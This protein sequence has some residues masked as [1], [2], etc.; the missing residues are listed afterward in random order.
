MQPK[1]M[2][3]ELKSGYADDGPA[4]IGMAF[5][6]KTGRTIYF[7]GLVLKKGQ[8]IKGNCYELQSGDEYWVSGIK[9]RGGDRHWAGKGKIMVDKSILDEYLDF[10]GMYELNKQRYEIVELNNVPSKE[11]ANEIENERL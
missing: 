8:G 6:S 9:E 4:W 7:N 2:Y 11:W 10:R 5:F 1:L 3:V